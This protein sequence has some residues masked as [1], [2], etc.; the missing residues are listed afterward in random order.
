MR[1]IAVRT[2]SRDD[3]NIFSS[4]RQLSFVA[5]ITAIKIEKDIAF[6]FE[7]FKVATLQSKLDAL[8]LLCKRLREEIDKARV[9][10]NNKKSEAEV[11]QKKLSSRDKKV[12][13]KKG[14]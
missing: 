5:P 6:N 14:E 11:L 12:L 7:S 9:N 3:E 1:L 10:F 13:D 2:D 4:L 8:D